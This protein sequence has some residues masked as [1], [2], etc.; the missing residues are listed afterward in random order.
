LRSSQRTSVPQPTALGQPWF[1]KIIGTIAKQKRLIWLGFRGAIRLKPG[2]LF[3]MVQSMYRPFLTLAA[4]LGFLAV[5]LGAFGAHGLASRLANVPD[6]ALRLDWWKT[7]AH[8]HLAHALALGLTAGVLGETRVARFA[9][10]A[11]ALGIL[12][13]SGS[14]YTMTLTGIRWLGAVTP[15]GGLALLVGWLLLG[16]AALT[17]RA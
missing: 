1:G 2:A 5:A 9:C 12:L 4:G 10:V 6:G 17:S 14:L 8:Y 11:F 13:F 16:W 15:L 3:R 7:A